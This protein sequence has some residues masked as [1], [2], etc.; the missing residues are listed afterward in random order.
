MTFE[1]QL[2][3]IQEGIIQLAL[4]YISNNTE[5]IGRI[6]IY[7]VSEN[8]LTIYFAYEVGGEIVD[9]NFLNASLPKHRQKE[10]PPISRLLDLG[11]G[12]LKQMKNFCKEHG[13]E[14]PTEL[15]LVYDTQTQSLKAK[16]SYDWRYAKDETL[17]LDT[18]EE[19]DKWL[20]ELRQGQGSGRLNKVDR[21]L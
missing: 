16:Y 12:D 4:E 19:F 15:W 9:V 2:M 21:D 13:K 18:T 14:H 6:F 8:S 7:G 3:Q 20:E 11:I 5:D 10:N 17:D 1:D